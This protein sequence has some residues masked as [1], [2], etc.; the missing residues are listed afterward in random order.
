MNPNDLDLRLLRSFLA[1]AQ[2][3]KVSTGFDLVPKSVTG[4]DEPF[5]FQRTSSFD[6][7][8]GGPVVGTFDYTLYGADAAWSQNILWTFYRT[9]SGLCAIRVNNPQRLFIPAAQTKRAVLYV[10]RLFAVVRTNHP[11]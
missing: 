5:D 11:S 7:N 3:G 1:V 6:L 9:R 10:N 2:C 8:T 4:K